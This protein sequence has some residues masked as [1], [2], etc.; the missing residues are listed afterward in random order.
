MGDIRVFIADDNV[1]IR[2]GLRNLLNAEERISVV[3]EAS[4]GAEAIQWMRKH[5]ADVVLMD[6]RMPVIDGISATAEIVRT[7]PEMKILILTVT[8]DPT[9][10]ARSIYVGAK[11]YLVY[12][13][14]SPE[15]LLNSVYA[16]ASG[17]EIQPSPAVALALGN[18]PKDEQR[19]DFLEKQ[20]LLD[21]L[22]ARETEILDLIADGRSNAEIAQ[23]LIVEEKT[24]KNHIT[25]L[26]SKLNINSRYEA[27]RLKLGNLP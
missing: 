21:P 23:V 12:S 26:Y 9:T 20:Q 22:T 6:I 16:V 3:G 24:I 11:G 13:H 10:L 25:R 15:E 5:A 1:V 4:T 2:Q 8:E 19:T 18:I 14:F 17:K 7:R 27:I